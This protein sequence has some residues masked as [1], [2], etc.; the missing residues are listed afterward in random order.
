MTAHDPST[1]TGASAPTKPSGSRAVLVTGGA[2]RVGRSICRAFASA[3]YDVVLTYH[4][5]SDEAVRA[6]RELA[7]FNVN[8]SIHRVDLGDPSQAIEFAERMAVELPHLDALVHNASAYSPSPLADLDAEDALSQYRVNALAP[9]LLSQRLAGR[10]AESPSQGGGSIVMMLDIHALGLPRRN[11]SAYAMSKAALAQAMRTL[12]RELAPRVRVNGVAPGV[13][14]WPETGP[15]S[16][17]EMQERYLKSVPL[18]RA[19][20]PEEAAE[21]VLWLA[22]RATYC[23]GQIINVDGGRALL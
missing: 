13:V 4:T 17:R 20:T 14:K 11:Y 18:D 8:C 2:K 7:K 19:G 16:D 22:T 10:L 5:S 15:E 1:A 21:A 3:G 12:A 9:L 6:Q 23:T